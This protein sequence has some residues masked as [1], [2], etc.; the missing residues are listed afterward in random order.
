M[1]ERI[2]LAQFDIDTR[3]IE[4]KIASNMQKINALK[5]TIGETKATVKDYQNQTGESTKK[6]ADNTKQQEDA[7]AAFNEGLISQKEYNNV[8]AQTSEEIRKEEQNVAK[9]VEEEREQLKVV[10]NLQNQV[11]QL[12]AENRELNK[13]I[14]S[15]ISEIDKMDTGLKEI[16]KNIEQVSEGTDR[17]RAA[18]DKL[19]DELSEARKKANDLAAEMLEL[20]EAGDSTSQ[21]YQKLKETWNQASQEAFEL[22]QQVDQI[23]K[24][25]R[26]AQ[27][28]NRS[29]YEILKDQLSEARKEALDLGAALVLLAQDGKKDTDE[30]K[31]LNKVWEDSSK[32]AKE[33]HDELLKIEKSTGD[34]RRNV[35]NYAGDIKDAFSELGTGFAQILSGNI[36]QG[37]STMKNSFDSIK[38]AAK[39]LW[40]ELMANPLVALAAAITAIA[41]GL[42]QGAKAV[43]EYNLEVNKLNKEIEGLTNLTGRVVDRIREYATAMES[44]F[45]KDFQDSVREINSLMKDFGLTAEDAYKLYTEGLAKGGATNSEFGDSIREYGVLFAQNGYSAKDFIDLL[46]TGIDLDIYSDKL[47][48][49]IKEAGLALNE[50]TKATRDALVNAFGASFSDDL[51]KRIRSGETTVKLAIDEIASQAQKV[52]LNT[53]QIAQLNADVFKGAGEDAGGLLKL[54]EAVN[55]ANSK[56]TE[57]LTDTQKATIKLSDANV[58]LEKAKTE[59]FKSEGLQN[60]TSNIEILWIKVK[61]AFYEITKWFR[62]GIEWVNNYTGSSKALG[63]IWDSM[64]ALG[65]SFMQVLRSIKDAFSDLLSAIGFNDDA[66]GKWLKTLLG[67]M[68][69]LNLIK[70]ALNGLVAGLKVFTNLVDAA[71]TSIS[72]FVITAKSIFKQVIDVAVMLKNLDFSGALEKLKSFSVADELKKAFVEAKRL[73]DFEKAEK[74]RREAEDAQK[75]NVNIKG[76]NDNT[77]AS[78][79]AAAKAEKERQKLLEKQ[80]KEEEAARKKAQ[81]ELDRAAKQDLSNAKE[82]ANV[83]IQATQAELAEYIAMNA[84]KLKSDKRLTQARVDEIS[85]YLEDVREKMQIANDQEKNQKIQSLNDQ[86][87]AIKGNSQQDLDQKRNLVAQ[88]AA[89]EK[90]Y[91]A[92]EIQINNDTNEKKKEVDEKFADQKIEMENLTR[93]LS[94]QKRIQ[95]LEE[96]GYN[97]YDM[98]QAQLDNETEQKLAAIIKENELKREID[99]ENYDINAEIEA[100]RR[101]LE[102]QISLEQDAIKKQNLQNLLD[103]FGIMQKEYAER[104]KR[105]AQEK[106]YAKLSAFANVAAAMSNILGKQTVLAKTAAIAEATI[107]TY[108]GASKAFAQGGGIWGIIQGA[109][110]IA[111]GLA[112]VANIVGIDTGGISAGFSSIASTAG[113]IANKK[114][115]AADGMLIGPSHDNGGIPIKTPSGIIEAEGGEV[116]INK[117]SSAMYRDVLSQINQMGGGV[118]FAGGGVMPGLSLSKLPTIQNIFKQQQS[119]TLDQSSLNAIYEAIY[120]GGSDGMIRLSENREIQRGAKF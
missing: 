47:P 50:Q 93:A 88:K 29:P 3:L 117:K 83:A 74:K 103:Q 111:A 120:S 61:T 81:A 115:K 36:I 72:A 6:I 54:I 52:G 48:D 42:Y 12:S 107:N 92:K 99:Q 32:G 76:N 46:N 2:N 110:V 102:N 28:D 11:G 40:I 51:L 64:S 5:T 89:V 55:M 79:D 73:S 71:K 21:S 87:E 4:D 63:E 119:L 108:V 53:Q 67:A 31:R 18:F 106:E 7:K 13:S 57:T 44:V 30:Y 94:F 26:R 100:Q 9:L 113:S 65:S 91:S 77:G 66:T 23:N 109:A 82:R 101:I 39:E 68:N 19:K 80:R 84:E 15:G 69:P 38:I 8:I 1:A 22:H 114:G 45:G 70:F 59:A 97:E 10:N 105:I 27:N 98:Q 62:E 85:K 24:S 96:Q 34:S 20:E 60:F 49:A 56:Q 41:V 17:S 43:V 33:L 58:A 78:A 16:D 37:F 25:T 75:N 118:K 86:L 104:E 112:N 116:I 95:D 35:G 90:E 14:N